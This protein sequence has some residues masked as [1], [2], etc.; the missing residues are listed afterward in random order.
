MHIVAL[1]MRMMSASNKMQWTS[2]SYATYQKQLTHNRDLYLYQF[3]FC[4]NV[5]DAIHSG[6]IFM[7]NG[8]S[9]EYESIK[10]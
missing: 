7:C 6:I 4:F 10:Y 3:C 1:K 9:L 2:F 5:L 8:I